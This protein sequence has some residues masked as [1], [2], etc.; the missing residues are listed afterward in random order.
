MPIVLFGV[1]AR[2]DRR[3]IF[4]GRV[5]SPNGKGQIFCERGGGNRTDSVTYR[6]H[7]ALQCGC[8]VLA[9]E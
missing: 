6:K 5:G 4:S 3:T 2:V 8:S 7:V 1:V 9:A